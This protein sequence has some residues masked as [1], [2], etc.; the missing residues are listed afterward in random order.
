MSTPST[1]TFTKKVPL[2]QSIAE[3]SSEVA[4]FPIIISSASP[5]LFV[6]TECTSSYTAEPEASLIS[7]I[8]C[9]PWL[10]LILPLTSLTIAW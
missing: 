3:K 9:T 2:P 10:D 8:N 5:Y 4:P 6:I 1:L 7:K